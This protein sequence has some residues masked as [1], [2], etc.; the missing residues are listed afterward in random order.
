MFDLR[1]VSI[2]ASFH[3]SINFGLVLYLR[4]CSNV[5]DLRKIL[6]MFST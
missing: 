6:A 5:F 4:K 3:D 2:L 1:I